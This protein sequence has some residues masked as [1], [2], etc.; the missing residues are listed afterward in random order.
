MMDF[1]SVSNNS[2]RLPPHDTS[3]ERSVLGAMLFS[4]DAVVDAFGVVEPSHFYR[5]GHAKIFTAMQ[6]LFERNDPIDEVTVQA[7]LRESGEL[8]AVG[9]VSFLASL[10][11]GVPSAANVGH[12]ARIVRE[13][14]L[15]RRLIAAGSVIVSKGYSNETDV[16]ELLDEA[17]SSIF[18]ITSDSEQRAYV[19]LNETVKDAFKALEKRCEDKSAIT[20]VPSGFTRLDHMTAGFQPSDLI[21]VAGRPSMGKTALALNMA[22]HAAIAEGKKVLIFS[23]EMSRD[24]LTMRMLCSQAKI[25]STRMRGGFLGEHDWPKLSAAAEVLSKAPV[26]L[27]DTG[28]ISLMEVRAKCRRM[29]AEL[30]LDLVIIDYLQLMQG[31][32]RKDGSRE[33]EIS[34]ISRGLKALAR[35]V[36]VPVIAL[37]QLNRALEQRQDKRPMLSDLRE[38]GAIEQDADVIAFVYRDEYYNPESEDRG[39]AEI[40]VG[41]QRNGATGNIKL[42]FLQEYT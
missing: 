30:G 14:A 1:E 12:Y 4:S 15:K 9:G 28:A 24:Q 40:I 5:S 37:S 36:N 23:L 22:Q 33:R 42:N 7:C 16:E 11:D 6:A 10:G 27:D 38:S 13:Q 21:I 41:K 25:D 2:R 35:E 3:A 29:Q 8:E 39:M 31:K 17:E 26:Q 18:Q 34:E 32:V 19:S 20:G